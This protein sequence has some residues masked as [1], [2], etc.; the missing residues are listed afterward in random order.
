V[1]NFGSFVEQNPNISQGKKQ[2]ENMPIIQKEIEKQSRFV[3]FIFQ[4][5]QRSSSASTE[6]I[7]I[8]NKVNK[9]GGIHQ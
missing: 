1:F 5:I 9:I 2:Q 8:I 4:S 3:L 7:S 6:G